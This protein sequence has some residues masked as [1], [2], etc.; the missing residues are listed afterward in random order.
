MSN[1]APDGTDL[2]ELR[3]GLVNSITKELMTIIMAEERSYGT[4]HA[5]AVAAGFIDAF[6]SNLIFNS[7]MTPDATPTRVAGATRRQSEAY[8]AMKRRLEEAIAN[9]FAGGFN[10]FDPASDPEYVVQVTPIPQVSPST[11]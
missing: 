5:H 1:R 3:V 9:G 8:V 6:I 10:A 7:L 11:H 4:E 2:D